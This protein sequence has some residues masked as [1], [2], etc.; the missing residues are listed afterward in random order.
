MAGC[1]RTAGEKVAATHSSSGAVA[2]CSCAC[3][4]TVRWVQSVPQVV[5]L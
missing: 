4:H 2:A 3:G 5:D 1:I